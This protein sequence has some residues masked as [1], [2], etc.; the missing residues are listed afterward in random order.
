M[1]MY[2]YEYEYLLNTHIVFIK[3]KYKFI[4][5]VNLDYA[6]YINNIFCIFFFFGKV[7][8]KLIV[9]FIRSSISKFLFWNTK[10]IVDTFKRRCILN[11]EEGY[12]PSGCYVLRPEG[13]AWNHDVPTC[14][15]GKEATQKVVC[16][17]LW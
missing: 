3:G 5:K 14:Q 7:T 1:N 8:V 4:W 6:M 9:G 11:C 10:F 16:I 12:A 15:E 13:K 17:Y 2:N